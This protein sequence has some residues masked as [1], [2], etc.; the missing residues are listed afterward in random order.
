[1]AVSGYT[2]VVAVNSG[3]VYI[4]STLTPETVDWL[5]KAHH[6]TPRCPPHRHARQYQNMLKLIYM[7]DLSSSETQRLSKSNTNDFPQ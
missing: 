5:A 3:F 7:L 1:M 4:L 6:R 2:S